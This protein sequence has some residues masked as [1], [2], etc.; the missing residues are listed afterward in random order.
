MNPED[1]KTLDNRKGE[2]VYR[3][4]ERHRKRAGSWKGYDIPG[5]QHNSMKEECQETQTSWQ[6]VD[7]VE[8]CRPGL[9]FG[10]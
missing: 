10:P 1:Q 7:S 6:R 8:L 4:R 9:S 2:R 5:I 3:Q